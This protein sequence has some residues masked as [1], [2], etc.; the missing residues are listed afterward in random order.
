MSLRTANY[1]VRFSDAQAVAVM[2]VEVERQ[3]HARGFDCW[4]TSAN[5]GK[6]K[7]HSLHDFGLAFDFRTKH[8][9]ADTMREI[10]EEIKQHLLPQFDVLWEDQGG[11]NEH[12]HVEYHP[13]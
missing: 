10:Y 11:N 9:P 3:F 4:I 1:R 13:D 8:V 5:D 7:I 2:L 6:H 12:L